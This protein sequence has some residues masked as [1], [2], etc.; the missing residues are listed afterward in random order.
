MILGPEECK[1]TATGVT[2]CLEAAAASEAVQ[3]K[4]RAK[5]SSTEAVL[6]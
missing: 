6:T 2:A 1:L 4:R 5:Y 3:R